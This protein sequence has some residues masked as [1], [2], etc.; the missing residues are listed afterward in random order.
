[1]RSFT[2]CVRDYI[3]KIKDIVMIDAKSNLIDLDA[4]IDI[5]TD[6]KEESEETLELWAVKTI[7][8]KESS[9]CEM[10]QLLN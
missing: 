8:E 2:N 7:R 4:L 5:L 3:L 1:V 9:K 10:N 6:S